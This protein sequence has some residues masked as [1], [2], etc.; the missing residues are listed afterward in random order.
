MNNLLVNQPSNTIG[1]SV[2][3][4]GITTLAMINAPVV[5]NNTNP[6]HKADMQ[7][8]SHYYLD[9]SS[10][11]SNYTYLT[12]QNLAT[13]FEQAIRTFYN[14]LLTKQ[15]RLGNEFEKILNDHCWDLYEN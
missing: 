5:H 11:A 7:G 10:T 2:F 12:E 4:A 13:S 8:Y 15:E 6:S 14:D 1:S 9:E 3:F